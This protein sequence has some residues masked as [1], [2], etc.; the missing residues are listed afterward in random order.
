MKSMN[1]GVAATFEF[2]EPPLQWVN[3]HLARHPP[4]VFGV[5]LV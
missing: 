5:A 1:I 4:H 2:S 3:D